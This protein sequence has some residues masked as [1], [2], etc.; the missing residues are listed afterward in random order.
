VKILVIDDDPAMTDLLRLILSPIQA[1]IFTSNSGPE[2]VEIA[3]SE[4]PD[5]II[6]DLM[7][8][9]MDGWEVCRI[10]RESSNVPILIMS[11]IDNPG[12]IAKALDAGA[13]DFL[14]K[15]VPSGVLIAHIMN[16]TRPRSLSSQQLSQ[17]Q[18]A[19]NHIVK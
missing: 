13:D 18:M 5:I 3:A 7:M 17:R 9:E 6:L 14:V 10:V 12:L 8:P 15:P 4:N 2:G 19:F 1:A 16:L 11:A